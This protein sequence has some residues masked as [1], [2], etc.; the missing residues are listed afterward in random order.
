MS[1]TKAQL[2]AL[3][4]KSVVLT[5]ADV[6]TLADTESNLEALSAASFTGYATQG[7][8]V[9]HSTNGIL[10]LNEAKVAAVLGSTAAFKDSD[11]VTLADTATNIQ[12]LSAT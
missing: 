1:F 4:T 5:A 6:V 3:A 8:D 10:V 2:D 9:I 7:V 11:A 12:A